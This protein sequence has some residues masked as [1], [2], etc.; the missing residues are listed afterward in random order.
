M[1]GLIAPELVWEQLP[2]LV[3]ERLETKPGL[4]SNWFGSRQILPGKR[5]SSSGNSYWKRETSE[6]PNSV[7]ETPFAML[8]PK[9]GAGPE[10][11]RFQLEMALSWFTTQ[12]QK[13]EAR[14]VCGGARAKPLKLGFLTLH[15]R[16]TAP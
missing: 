7:R 14:E 8:G 2:V 4:V 13:F 1:A 11:D 3:R 10:T 16:Q 15:L 5:Q 9:K 6:Q 12:K